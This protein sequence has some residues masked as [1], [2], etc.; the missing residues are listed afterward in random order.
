MPTYM[1][2]N[3]IAGLVLGPFDAPT[4]D[5]AVEA[6]IRDAGYRDAAHEALVLETSV[7][8]LRDE[9]RVEEID[10]PARIADIARSMVEYD[11]EDVL[12]DAAADTADHWD[13]GGI[14]GAAADAGI[15]SALGSLLAQHYAPQIR[16]AYAVA[17]R[18]WRAAVEA[19]LAAR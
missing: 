17:W 12:F 2:A 14:V 8:K 19:D 5:E 11:R 16:D 1:I 4:P 10:V 15:G 3:R 13:R 9:L 18:A 7:D 6:M